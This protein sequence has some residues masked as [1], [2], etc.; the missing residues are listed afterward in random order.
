M[1]VCFPDLAAILESAIAGDRFFRAA[2]PSKSAFD[3][4]GFDSRRSDSLDYTGLRS[5]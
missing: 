5:L 2:T 4:R 1:I 3:T